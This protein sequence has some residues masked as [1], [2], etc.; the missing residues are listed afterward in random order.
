VRFHSANRRMASGF[1]W[2]SAPLFLTFAVA[3][4][5]PSA[6]LADE[7]VFGYTYTTDLLP[8]RKFE[9][10]QWST[11]RFT[12]AH[13]SFWL[14]E[15]RTEFEYGVSDRFQLSFYANYAA[16]HASGE[17]VDGST[18]PPETFAGPLFDPSKPFRDSKFVGVSLEGIYRVLS[19]YKHPVGLALYFEPTFGHQLRK[20][21]SKL[22]LQKNFLD[23]R[24]V[25]AFNTTVELERRFLEGDPSADPASDDFRSHW[26]HE[27]DVNFSTGATYRLVRSWSFGGEFINEREF[28]RFA[29][30]NTESA[31]NNAFYIGPVA[32]YGGRHFFGTLTFL[33]QL[34]WAS[35]YTNPKSN[36]L[37]GGRTYADDFEKYRIR[38]KVGW[39]F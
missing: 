4:L 5:M 18:T 17:S 37:F 22:I 6:I 20:Y 19:P 31:T 30:W 21:E 23:D 3:I 8:R 9:V 34:P 13:G 11:T 36:V 29:F 10:E 16:T 25:W 2:F 26:D 7:P 27:A 35:D 28:S 39:Y 24:L 32:H 33:T 12:K 14:Q 1:K 15:N 38:I